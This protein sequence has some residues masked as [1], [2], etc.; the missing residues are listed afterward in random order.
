MVVIFFCEMLTKNL[1]P[2]PQASR[3]AVSRL[4]SPNLQCPQMTP[5]LMQ[6]K[7]KKRTNKNKIK[8]QTIKRCTPI[9]GDRRL[10]SIEF[11]S[12]TAAGN[13][14]PLSPMPCLL[15]REQQN[16]AVKF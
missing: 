9:R 8:K 16:M 1:L 2:N 13:A 3:W 4:P 11:A 14:A 6:N 15:R 5:A 12:S 10:K 7:N